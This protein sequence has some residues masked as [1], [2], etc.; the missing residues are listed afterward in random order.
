MLAGGV[1]GVTEP[2]GGVTEPGGGV[3]EPGGGVTEP[4]GGVTEPGGGVTEPGGVTCPGVT[5][6]GVTVPG[7]TGAGVV[8]VGTGSGLVDGELH[9][10]KKNALQTP[11]VNKLN[12]FI[13]NIPFR[14]DVAGTTGHHNPEVNAAIDS[15]VGIP[16]NQAPNKAIHT[17]G[18][19]QTSVHYRT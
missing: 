16:S 14:R 13:S 7:V 18:V 17:V 3:T 5:V 4:G 9:A 11:P 10:K 2:G 8:V 12:L 1:G 19:S 6:V 15:V